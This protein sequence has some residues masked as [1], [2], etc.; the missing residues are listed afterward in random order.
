MVRRMASDTSSGLSDLIVCKNGITYFVEIKK[1]AKTPLRD[2]QKDFK[3]LCQHFGMIYIKT[4]SFEDLKEQIK[5]LTP[6]K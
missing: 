6:R 5:N 4:H 3:E 2:S 1:D